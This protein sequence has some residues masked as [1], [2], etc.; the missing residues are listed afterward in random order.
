M[1]ELTKEQMQ[2]ALVDA[3]RKA[4]GDVIRHEG[5]QPYRL[6]I[7]CDEEPWSVTASIVECDK[8][9]H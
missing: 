8:C 2:R 6:V 5:P 9:D 4:V 1:S 3:W 7:S